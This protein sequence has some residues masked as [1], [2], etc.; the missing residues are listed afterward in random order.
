M[1]VIVLLKLG[2]SVLETDTV[3]VMWALTELVLDIVEVRVNR[4]VTV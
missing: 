3:L 1:F 4:G 2:E